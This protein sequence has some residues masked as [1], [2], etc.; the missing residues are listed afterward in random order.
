MAALGHAG[1]KVQLT[2]GSVADVRPELKG[3]QPRGWPPGYTWDMV[4]GVYNVGEKAIIAGNVHLSG[5]SGGSVL[6]HETGHAL[7]GILLD[8]SPMAY[9]VVGELRTAW[10]QALSDDQNKQIS[11]YFRQE[12]AGSRGPAGMD[13]MWA[14]SYSLMAHHGLDSVRKL[15]GDPWTKVF[16]KNIES[17]REAGRNWDM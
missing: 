14:E 12:A 8:T 10:K 9:R 13:E 17:I 11:P 4:A 2:D 1:I 16:A 3:K 6:A 7:Y 15:F 5:S